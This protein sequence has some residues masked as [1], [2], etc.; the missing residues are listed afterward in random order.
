MTGRAADI[1]L[2]V[3]QVDLNSHRAERLKAISESVHLAYKN[4]VHGDIAEFGI[5][6]GSSIHAICATLVALEKSYESLKL[7]KKIVHG[8]DSFQGL[9]KSQL[10]GD[11]DAPMVQL[12]IW[13]EGKCSSLGL[14][15][16]SKICRHY[17]PSDQLELYEGWFNETLPLLDREVKFC[18]VNIDCD[19]Y[20]STTPV[21]DELFGND[22]LSDGCILLFDDYFEN[23]ASKSLGQ[24]KAWEECKAKYSPDFTELGTYGLSG[25]RCIVHRS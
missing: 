9:P 12:G 10:A 20:E 7:P 16:I 17:L 14:V 24:R 8:F 25:W 5:G 2:P 4:V 21:L 13:G 19:L 1:K 3:Y 6:T 23:R 15:G 11:I 18:L 22:R